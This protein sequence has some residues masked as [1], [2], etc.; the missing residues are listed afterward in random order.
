KSTGPSWT[1]SRSVTGA[2][3]PTSP[4][5]C[6]AASR[7]RCAA[8]ATAARR[9]PSASRSTPPPAVATRTPSCAPGCLPTPPQQALDTAC[10]VHLAGLGHDPAPYPRTNLRGHP[11]RRGLSWAADPVSQRHGDQD[12]Q[13]TGREAVRLH[14]GTVR[15]ADG[16]DD[17]QAQPG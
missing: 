2:H 9:T 16:P 13:A 8:C 17:G 4:A 7:S 5:S 1:K 10:T 15:G 6:P 3:S 14:R 11:L 12:P